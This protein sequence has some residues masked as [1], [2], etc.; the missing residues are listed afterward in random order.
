MLDFDLIPVGDRLGQFHPVKVWPIEIL[1]SIAFGTNQMVMAGGIDFKAYCIIN[2]MNAL[3]QAILFKGRNC[4]V[5]SIQGNSL[6]ILADLVENILNRW[7]IRMF[8]QSFEN[9]GSLMSHF[10]TLGLT[11]LFE[12]AHHQ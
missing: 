10:E 2:V 12:T 3:D 1:Y 11:D 8:E 6:E 7:M 9:L 4:P 5:N